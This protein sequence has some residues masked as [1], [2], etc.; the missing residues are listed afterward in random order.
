MKIKLLADN[1]GKISLAKS[2]IALSIRL[3]DFQNENMKE[4]SE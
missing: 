3:K 2:N 4:N 1:Q